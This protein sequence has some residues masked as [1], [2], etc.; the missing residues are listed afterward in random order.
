MTKEQEKKLLYFVGIVFIL[1]SLFLPFYKV[2][3]EFY[4]NHISEFLIFSIILNFIGFLKNSYYYK[5]ALSL[6]TTDIITIVIEWFMCK[7]TYGDCGFSYGLIIYIIGV[8]CLILLN[9]IDREKVLQQGNQLLVPVNEEALDSF[10]LGKY[11]LGLDGGDTLSDAVIV[12]DEVKRELLITIAEKKNIDKI[13]NQYDIIPEN[14]IIKYDNI[15]E[16]RLQTTVRMRTEKDNMDVK[17]REMM[18]HGLVRFG[19]GRLTYA[20]PEVEA[21]DVQKM[22]PVNRIFI[23]FLDEKEND[24]D[25]LVFETF[26]EY[27]QIL[28]NLQDKIKK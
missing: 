12:D 18:V 2:S 14:H 21:T 11:I 26:N 10:V 28:K 13:N 15:K 19:L 7:V 23:K 25:E 24:E 3:D 17:A 20:L 9:L 27:E 8:I 4:A 16:I 5:G 6:I 1:I 22:I